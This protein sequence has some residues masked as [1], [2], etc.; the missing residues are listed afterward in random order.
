MDDGKLSRGPMIAITVLRVL[1]GWHFLYEGL[2]KLTSPSWSAAGY[3]KEA[4][5]PFA[6]FV[7][8]DRQPAEPARQRGPDHDVGAD[9]RR[10]LLILGLFTRLASLAGIGVHP[11][12]LSRATRRSWATST[13]SPPRAAT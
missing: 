7:P 2:T 3:M 1:V 6:G 4:R 12:V 8:V 11:A 9:D 13:R 5:G 10:R